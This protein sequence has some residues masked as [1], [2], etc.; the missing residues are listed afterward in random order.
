MLRS[1]IIFIALLLSSGAS[2]AQS[3]PSC[4]AGT[5]EA[6]ATQ[7]LEACSAVLNAGNL[8]DSGRAA[9]LKIRARSYHR[10]DKLSDAVADYEAALLFAPNDPEL[11]LRRGWIAFDE[12][13]FELVFN[14]ARRA[15]ELSPK[16]AEVYGLVGA[17]YA[18]TGKF[19]EALAAYDQAVRLEPDSPMTRINRMK[20]LRYQHKYGEALKEAEFILKLPDATITRPALTKLYMKDTTDRIAAGQERAELLVVLGRVDDARRAFDQA[21]QIDPHAQT[22]VGRASFNLGL[23]PLDLK[24]AKFRGVEEDVKRSIELDPDFWRARYV[25]AQIYYH[26]GQ[27]DDAA[28]EFARGIE[29]YPINGTMRWWRATTLRKLGRIEE[30]Q[31]EA[32]TAFEVDPGFML[33]K[34]GMLRRQ[35]Y[36]PELR[37]DADVAS[38]V[39]DAIRACMLDAECG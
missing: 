29:L 20:L 19:D 3:R 34:I 33:Q 14:H 22:F 17:A 6:D 35:G 16:Y 11:H 5:F 28:R 10:L 27:Y 24:S 25:Q 37:P 4:S 39:A 36:L 30:A 8:G 38:A 32:I 9:A 21:V 26:S 2:F 13:N 31:S 12:Q 18:I 15:L 23:G 7:A 1:G